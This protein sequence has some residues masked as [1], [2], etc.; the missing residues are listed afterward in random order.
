MYI[1][2]K[3]GANFVYGSENEFENKY[4]RERHSLE[5]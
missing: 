4:I 3:L 5:L 1:F 2:R